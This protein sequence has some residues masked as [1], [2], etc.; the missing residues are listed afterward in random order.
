MESD[1]ADKMMPEIG[2]T[3]VHKEGAALI[4]EWVAALDGDCT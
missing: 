2:R 4:A 1:E 3:T